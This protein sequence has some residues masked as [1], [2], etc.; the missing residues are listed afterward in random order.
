M[1]QMHQMP[2]ITKNIKVIEFLKCNILADVSG[3]FNKLF[4]KDNDGSAFKVAD[5]LASIISGCYILGRR[6]GISY[7]TI[8]MKIRANLKVGTIQQNELEGEFGD[9]SALEAHL[10]G[11]R[12]FARRRA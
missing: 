11:S 10:D 12:S 2:N 3:L 7:E 5:V 1:S 8:D 4:T 9:L 6:L